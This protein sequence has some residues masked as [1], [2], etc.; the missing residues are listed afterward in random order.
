M[1]AIVKTK[2][3][4]GIEVQ[5]RPLPQPGEN[6]V[7]I[8]VEA[9][10]VTSCIGQALSMVK[11]GGKVVVAGIHPGPAQINPVDLVMSNKTLQGVLGYELQHWHRALDLMSSGRVEA[12][13]LIT[14]RLPLAKAE[15]GFELAAKKEAIK[16][17]FTP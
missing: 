14:H 12:E 15:E 7:L 16:V 3:G 6:D 11:R 8:R 2:P 17:V 10:G 13:A 9:A 1:K 4:R 5:D